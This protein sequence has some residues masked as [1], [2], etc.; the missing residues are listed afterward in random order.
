MKN[1]VLGLSV[2]FHPIMLKNLIL[3][4]REVNQVDDLILFVDQKNLFGM[5]NLYEKYNVKFFSYHL[6]EIV[7]SPIHNTK[8]IKFLE[9]L[10]DNSNYKNVFL[11][12]TKDVIFQ[13]N[14]FDNLPD[15]SLFVF[16][17]DSGFRIGDD[18][19]HNCWWIATAYGVDILSQ[20]I[21]NNIICSGTV[22][23]SYNK[24]VEFMIQIKNEILKI[25]KENHDI[26]K[27]MILDQA[28]VNYLCRM[29]EKTIKNVTIK[30]NGDMIGTLGI[31]TSQLTAEGPQWRDEVLIKGHTLMVN[32]KIPSI[33]HQYDRD[34]ILKK[35]Y[36]EKYQ[37]HDISNPI[38]TEIENGK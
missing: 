32:K 8:H 6:H 22:L 16:Q 34:P 21:N 12:D 19:Y 9:Y 30:K 4:F 28:I 11:T 2:N 26:F 10:E 35:I 29:N 15:D 31:S 36:D 24:I 38:K 7:D 1:V 25:R 20:I 3:S 14:P 17:E 5:R 27:G 33:L 37:L 23:G 13:N 18:P